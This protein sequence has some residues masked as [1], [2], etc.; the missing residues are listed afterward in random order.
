MNTTSR[1]GFPLDKA[2]LGFLM[3]GSTH[4]YALHERV[5]EELGRIWYMGMSNVYAKLKDLEKAAQVECTLDEESYPPRKVYAITREGRQSFLAWVREPV[6]S[7]RDI[8]VEFLAK[9]YFFH[10]LQL[11][12]VDAVLEAQEMLCQERLRELEREAGKGNQDEF[13]YI[14]SGFRQGRVWSTLEWLRV[15]RR[16]WT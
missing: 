14:V 8:R 15:V 12:G 4:G 6:T 7:V 2:L 5:Q 1:A 16:Q 3:Q 10:A 11:G 9:L 13:G